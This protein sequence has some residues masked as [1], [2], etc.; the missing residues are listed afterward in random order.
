MLAPSAVLVNTTLIF[1]LETFYVTLH[2]N[3]MC[4]SSF[5]NTIED[6][7][8]IVGKVLNDIQYIFDFKKMCCLLS[9][10]LVSQKGVLFIA[11]LFR[12]KL[13]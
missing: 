2:C 12:H 9:Q 8:V 1:L 13:V 7:F 10:C 4:S 3:A 6:L 11:L 5:N